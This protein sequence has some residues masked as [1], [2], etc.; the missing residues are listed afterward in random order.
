[1]YASASPSSP[2]LQLAALGD[3]RQ[4]HSPPVSRLYRRAAVI[5]YTVPEQIR[6]SFTGCWDGRAQRCGQRLP[7]AVLRVTVIKPR[8]PGL[9]RWHGAQDEYSRLGVKYG[10]YFV[11][12]RF[13][14]LII[15]TG[16]YRHRRFTKRIPPFFEFFR[17]R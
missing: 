11:Y 3:G 5:G 10:R 7:E 9:W 12:N 1:M 2:T 16:Y 4:T 13:H 15:I 6:P 14:A 17:M 8:L